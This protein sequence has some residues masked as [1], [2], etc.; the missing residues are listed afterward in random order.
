MSSQHGNQYY[1]H[2]SAP[3]VKSSFSPG[4]KSKALQAQIEALKQ[5]IVELQLDVQELQSQIASPP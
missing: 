2:I 4:D 3:G 5:T 1:K